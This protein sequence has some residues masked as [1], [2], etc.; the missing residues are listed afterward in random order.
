MDSPFMTTVAIGLA[1]CGNRVA[2][3]EFSY[4]RKSRIEGRRRFP[5]SVTALMED[6]Q[7]VILSLKSESTLIIG[8]KSL[9]GRIASLVADDAGVAGLVCIGY[10]FHP[11]GR[12][13][14]LRTEHLKTL[15]TPTLIVQ[16]ERDAF[17]NQSEVNNYNLSDS[18]HVEWLRDG[19]HSLKPRKKSGC[20]EADNLSRAVHLISEFV[21]QLT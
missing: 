3:F 21:C 17:G 19:D 9:G 18:I 10:P 14:K 4:M 16:G 20:T 1:K 8:G 15:V 2:R 13:D 6:W 11:P 7:T 5:D 12:F